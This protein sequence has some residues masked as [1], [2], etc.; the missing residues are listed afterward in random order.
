MASEAL[1]KL[2]YRTEKLHDLVRDGHTPQ[3]VIAK[4]ISKVV[5]IGLIYCG[6]ELAQLIQEQTQKTLDPDE[7]EET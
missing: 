6:A 5:E 2:R 7:K 4:Q 1:S 3:P